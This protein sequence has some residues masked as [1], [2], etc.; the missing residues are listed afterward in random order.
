MTN[1][2]FGIDLTTFKSHREAALSL[3]I[4]GPVGGGRSMASGGSEALYSRG[5]L[6]GELALGRGKLSARF[7]CSP[8]YTLTSGKL[9]ATSAEL[10]NAVC[11]VRAGW[12]C[13]FRDLVNGPRAIVDIY[14]PGD[15]IG[16]DAILRTRRSEEVLTLTSVTIDLIREEDALIDLMASQPT[17]LYLVWLLSQRQQRTDR[18]LSAVL[19][20]DARGRLATMILDFY[21]RLRRRKLIT[22]STYNLPLTQLQIGSYLGLTVVHVN[23]VLRL[24]RDERIVQMEKNFVTILDLE[25]L[26]SLAQQDCPQS[27]APSDEHSLNE[28]ACSSTEAAA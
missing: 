4:R 2:I 11:H 5:L 18:L 12:A 22:G 10:R 24:L 26:M 17:A 1:W 14:L 8:P 13:Q 23:R 19:C 7:D 9:L 27:V 28:L 21:T 3:E 20:L 15:V 16:L 25:R 6:R